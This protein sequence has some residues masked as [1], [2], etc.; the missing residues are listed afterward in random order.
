MRGCLLGEAGP[1]DTPPAADAA[2]A[3]QRSCTTHTGV[4]EA[5]SAV[6]SQEQQG[7]EPLLSI[8]QKPNDAA[9]YPA[10]C[11]MKLGMLR[12]SETAAGNQTM[13]R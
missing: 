10:G 1:V 13:H 4:W 2:P 12:P 11:T 9:V 6:Q 3:E 7:F 8:R 5:H